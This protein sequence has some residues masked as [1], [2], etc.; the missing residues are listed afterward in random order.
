MGT[1]V[2]A[3]ALAAM[4][5]VGLDLA[6]RPERHVRASAER[7]E[8]GSAVPLEGLSHRL[9]PQFETA[10]AYRVIGALIVIAAAALAAALLIGF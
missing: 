7:V 10:G 4:A 9:F 8:R 1:T 6:L 5:L 3:V 2:A